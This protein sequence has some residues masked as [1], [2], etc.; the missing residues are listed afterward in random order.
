MIGKAH[1]A[2]REHPSSPAF[3][4]IMSM[5]LL[6]GLCAAYPMNYW[7]VA[8]KLKHG[9]TTVRPKGYVSPMAAMPGMAAMSGMSGMTAM[10][11][12]KEMT[13]GGEMAKPE[14]GHGHMDMLP[15]VTT[16]TIAFVVGL[17][18]VILAVGVTIGM[19]FS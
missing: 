1:V 5:A 13:A 3:W 12:G 9:M 4:F 2:G 8:N 18:F 6:V 14:G 16:Q 15:K 10:P 7:L 19:S 11:A 17:S